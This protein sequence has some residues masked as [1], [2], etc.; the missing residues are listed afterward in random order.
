MDFP[1]R[2]RGVSL[3][4]ICGGVVQGARSRG[5]LCG[6]AEFVVDEILSAVNVV[7]R[8][9]YADSMTRR[10]THCASLLDLALQ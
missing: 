10:W 2:I 3:S 9:T 8:D 6:V 5:I 7:G 4:R 1:N